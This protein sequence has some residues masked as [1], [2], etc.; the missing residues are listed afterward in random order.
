MTRGAEMLFLVQLLFALFIVLTL[1]GGVLAMIVAI[2]M[3]ARTIRQMLK[4]D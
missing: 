1:V 3:L 2:G 4:G